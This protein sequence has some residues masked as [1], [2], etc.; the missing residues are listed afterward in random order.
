MKRY[1][2]LL[3]SAMPLSLVAASPVWL[4][5]SMTTKLY[6]A[7]TVHLLRDNDFPLPPAFESA[8]KQAQTLAFEVDIDQTRDP[9]FQQQMMQAIKLPAGTR[10]EQVLK[11]GTLDKLHAFLRRNGL[12][13][14]QFNGLKPSMIAM[15]MTIIELRKIGVNSAG[16]DDFFYQKAR[17][18]GKRILALESIQQ[19]IEFLTEM[20]Q[21]QEDM[22][23]LQT[24]R[25]IESL[26]SDFSDML[27]SW[28]QGDTRKLEDLFITPMKQ[29][30]G[31]VY[32][33]L[34]VNRNQNWLQ[35]LK[36]YLQTPDIE[37]VLVG[38]AHLPGE[39]GLLTLLKSA[40]YRISQ[41]Q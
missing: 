25:E 12:E 24:L 26:S 29:E 32:Q 23:I 9:A 20:G 18:D 4:V 30:F 39:D 31:P 40:G 11:P 37:M 19:Q 13:L 1:L 5:E 35:Q 21:G 38:S 6:L 16:V 3:L 22:M 2:L 28:R 34:I 36:A 8:Y 7:G 41:L 10:L 27:R 15:T 33:Q 17:H 14:D